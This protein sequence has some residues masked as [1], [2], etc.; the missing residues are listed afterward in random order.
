LALLRWS[1]SVVVVGALF[2]SV[3]LGVVVISDIAGE[4]GGGGY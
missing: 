2:V 4:D 3:F 1:P